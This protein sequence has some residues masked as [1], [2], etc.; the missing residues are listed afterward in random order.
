MGDPKHFKKKYSTSLHPW[1]RGEIELY[2]Q[3][4]SE[5]GLKNRREILIAASFLKK[6]KDLA[7]KLIAQKTFQGEKEKKQII[8]KLQKL[9]LLPANA[10]PDS[11]LE[12][13]LND[14]LNRRLQS[15]VYKNNLARSAKQA[16]QFIVHR[17]IQISGKEVTS[18]NYL[19]SIAEES[20]IMFNPRSQL[21]A[22]THPERLARSPQKAT[23]ETPQREKNT[24]EKNGSKKEKEQKKKVKN[25]ENRR[26]K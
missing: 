24:P 14:I 3:L 12:L 15:M 2:K 18:P 10:E 8:S 7:K 11:I 26:N 6:Y 23:E 16:R 9:G 5:F 20:Q 25:N 13:K 1:I 19:V 17:H 4:R 21:A 22:E